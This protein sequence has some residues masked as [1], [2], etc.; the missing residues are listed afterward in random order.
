MFIESKEFLKLISCYDID[1]IYI[2]GT[3]QDHKKHYYYWLTKIDLIDVRL[4]TVNNRNFLK[5]GYYPNKV[6]L[7][8][9]IK[10]NDMYFHL[11]G[12]YSKK[13]KKLTYER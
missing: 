3:E 6:I 11:R 13:A 10:F 8:A 5:K 7:E 12:E 1:K 4:L 2:N 9:S